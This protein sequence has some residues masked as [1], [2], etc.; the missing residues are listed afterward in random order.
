MVQ[1]GI[2]EPCHSSDLAHSLVHIPKT[3]LNSIRHS[4][5]TSSLHTTLCPTFATFEWLLQ[6]LDTSLDLIWQRHTSTSHLQRLVD[7]SRRPP[8]PEG[9]TNTAAFQWDWPILAAVFQRC[10]DRALTGIP[11]CIVY[12]DDMPIFFWFAGRPLNLRREPFSRVCSST[13]SGSTHQ[14]VTS[15]YNTFTF[16]FLGNVISHGLVSVDLSG[17]AQHAQSKMR[18][19][20]SIISRCRKLILNSYT[21]PTAHRATPA[22]L[23]LRAKTAWVCSSEQDPRPLVSTSCSAQFWPP[24]TNNCH[25]WHFPE[26]WA[27]PFL[28][29][30]LVKRCPLHMPASRWHQPNEKR[31]QSFES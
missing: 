21:N 5:A 13:T 27:P 12:V 31:S 6:E 8:R 22:P 28:N 3:P 11:R 10:V 29:Y 26:F 15:M 20:T 23:L 24:A 25:N 1:R 18:Q 9:Y 30:T 19:T 7:H 17:R 16:T 14:N 2:W 4:T